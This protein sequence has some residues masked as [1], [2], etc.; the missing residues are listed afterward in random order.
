MVIWGGSVRTSPR[1]PYRDRSR[2]E[3]SSRLPLDKNAYHNLE[4]LFEAQVDRDKAHAIE[5]IVQGWGVYL[6]CVEP[7]SWVD[8]VIVGMEPSF[9][10]ANSIE[11]ARKKVQEG[12]RNFSLSGRTLSGKE[13]D[14]LSLFLLSI[15]RFLLQPGQTCHMTDVSKG[16]MPVTVAALD[17]DRRY[18]E[19][20]PLLLEEI[21]IVGKPGAPVIAIGKQVEEFLQRYDLQRETSRPLYAVPHYSKQAS[22]SWKRG[23]EKDPGDFEAFETAE[24]GEGSRWA[25][26]LSRAKKQLVFAYRK[27]FEVIR[28]AGNGVHSD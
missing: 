16:A 17:R 1:L 23:A 13:S 26:D 11:A 14:T 3:R 5:R 2:L 10:W 4:R 25:A 7:E 20:Y 28:A 21:A 9:G 18:E 27:Q 24:F 12:F 8:Y 15:D 22:A 6:P 19:W